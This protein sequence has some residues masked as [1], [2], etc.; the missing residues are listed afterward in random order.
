M[1]LANRG[2][3]SGGAGGDGWMGRAPP[4]VPA[5]SLGQQPWGHVSNGAR[6]HG[7]GFPASGCREA[8]GKAGMQSRGAAMKPKTAL[9]G[10][11]VSTSGLMLAAAGGPRDCPIAAA[12][13]PLLPLLLGAASCAKAT[14]Q[15]SAACRGPR[16]PAPYP[17]HVRPLCCS[18]PGVDRCPAPCRR[19]PVHE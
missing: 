6:A 4:S 5:L 14:A 11:W 16:G 17:A 18:S 13:A 15:C 3:R 7:G 9:P 8:F 10:P 19:D 2:L 1:I 12:A